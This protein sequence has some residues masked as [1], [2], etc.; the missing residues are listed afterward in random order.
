MSEANSN[1]VAKAIS[2]SALITL[3]GIALSGPIGVAIVR[4][5]APQPDWEGIEVFVEY[6][7][8]VQALPFA[9]GFFLVFGFVGLVV[10]LAQIDIEKNRLLSTL[11]IV[12]ASIFASLICL[13]YI[14]QIVYIPNAVE[15]KSVIIESLTMDNPG[16]LGWALEMIGYG[17]LGLST[18]AIAPVLSG[19]E[20]PR[21]SIVIKWL[22]IV[23][24]VASV[25]GAI[26]TPFVLSRILSSP[27]VAGYYFW[28]GL[29][30]LLMV[31]IIVRYRFGK[32]ETN[33]GGS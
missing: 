3:I 31:L 5:T 25:G 24:G 2:I 21:L 27:S 13:N 26:A 23:N 32:L 6:Y 12:F 20:Q 9:F 11:A 33:E 7:A 14:I 22:L 18:L 16:S 28:N 10:S 15:K 29:V 17:V 4:A 8:P 19:S 30:A 1:S